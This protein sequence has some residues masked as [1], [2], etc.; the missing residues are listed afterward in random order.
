MKWNALFEWT[1]K[2]IHQ[3]ADKYW[4]QPAE[5]LLALQKAS[6]LTTEHANKV[7]VVEAELKN[8]RA[9]IA[10]LTNKLE[11]SRT[12]LGGKNQELAQL[13]ER[14][15]ALA[16]EVKRLEEERNEN[17]RFIFDLRRMV[18]QYFIDKQSWR[19]KI[20]ATHR[21]N[22]SLKEGFV[23]TEE[24]IRDQEQNIDPKEAFER[25]KTRISQQSTDPTT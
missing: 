15:E 25:L 14:S 17:V 11:E 3:F 23:I 2:K 8:S 20:F 10:E 12:S 5:A 16:V 18:I 6:D 9:L 13:S 21:F 24:E 19:E 1:G 22:K 7:L 4:P